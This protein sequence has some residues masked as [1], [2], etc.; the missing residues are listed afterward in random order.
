MTH[1]DVV[2]D[3]GAKRPPAVR[4]DPEVGYFR[5]LADGPALFI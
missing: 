2:F 5:W 3:D 4:A 1:G